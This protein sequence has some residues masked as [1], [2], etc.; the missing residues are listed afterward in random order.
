MNAGSMN[1]AWKPQ[2]DIDP[3]RNHVYAIRVQFVAPVVTA[4]RAVC[5]PEVVRRS[6]E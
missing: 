3:S 1:V 4:V 5:E 2:C 6:A